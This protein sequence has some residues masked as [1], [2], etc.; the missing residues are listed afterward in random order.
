[1]SNPR[2]G[3]IGDVLEIKN[4]LERLRAHYT[5]QDRLQSAIRVDD[6]INSLMEALDQS[7]SVL[8]VEGQTLDA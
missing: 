2:T 3:T 4:R 5:E 6:S 8:P 7:G 1:M